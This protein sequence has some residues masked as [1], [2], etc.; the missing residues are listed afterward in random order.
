MSFLYLLSLLTYK[1]QP[2][3][4]RLAEVWTGTCKNQIIDVNERKAGYK[5]INLFSAWQLTCCWSQRCWRE[6]LPRGLE[7]EQ[8]PEFPE[9][10]KHQ[11]YT[12]DQVWVLWIFCG[13][14]MLVE[15]KCI[16]HFAYIVWRYHACWAFLTKSIKEVEANLAS[17]KCLQLRFQRRHPQTLPMIIWFLVS[18]FKRHSGKKPNKQTDPAN[19][20]MISSCKL[21]SLIILNLIWP[22]DWPFL[23]S[24]LKR[25]SGEK[26]NNWEKKTNLAVFGFSASPLV[27]IWRVGLRTTPAN[28]NLLSQS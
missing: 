28:N 18:H 2:L 7:S 13:D 8:G 17:R 1:C 22:Y 19:D 21:H 15:H 5:I 26:P 27:A 16:L 3:R 6:V 24:H 9:T 20:H 4:F 23:V 25:H 12:P 14:I 10:L 11:E